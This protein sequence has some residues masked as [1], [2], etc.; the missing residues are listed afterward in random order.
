MDDKLTGRELVELVRRV[1]APGQRDHALAFLVD[2]PDERVPD[3]PSWRA[4]RAL[5]CEWAGLLD[6]ERE[7]LG[8]Q[9]VSLAWYRN[10]GSNNADLPETFAYGRG[11]L[12]QSH[13]DIEMLPAVPFGELF[14]THSLIVA[15]TELSATAPL[16]VA[17]RGQ[18]FRAATMPGFLPAMIP[19][20]RVD[21]GEVNRRVDILKELLD[22]A[23]SARV[24]LVAQGRRHELQLDLR[25]RTAH[26][27]GGLL[28][29]NGAAGNLPSG[30]AYIVP[31]EG[32][33]AGEPSLSAGVLPVELRGEI[34]LYE[35]AANRAAAV[36][37]SGPV[38][39]EERSLIAQE[40]AYANLAE[41]G[42]GVLGDFALKPVGSIL[43][44]EKLGLHIAFGR[45]DHFGGAVG[46]SAFTRPD[47]VVHIDRVYIPETQPRIAVAEVW[48]SGPQG[49]RLIMKDGRYSGLF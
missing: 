10:S 49:Q 46:P 20:L 33:R 21:Y 16:K 43:L 9:R 36:L 17:A 12:P 23:E 38:S 45:S 27:S 47:R 32:E 18:Q 15:P 31:Y 42:L 26:A 1:F 29:R 5:A 14:A 41:F 7:E 4:R 25:H 13:R 19:A 35:I 22:P 6:A 28:L 30:E 39:D 3:N 11:G 2:L 48:L 34:V 8:L 44:D 24:V 37:S 40:P